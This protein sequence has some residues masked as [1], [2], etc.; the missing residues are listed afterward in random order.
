MVDPFG[1]GK[2]DLIDRTEHPM[3]ALL[4]SSIT[5]TSL[6]FLLLVLLALTAIAAPIVLKLEAHRQRLASEKNRVTA[7]EAESATCVADARKPVNNPLE[8]A[9]FELVGL[10]RGSSYA[11]RVL[12][13]QNKPISFKTVLEKIRGEQEL[14]KELNSLPASGI[15]AVLRILQGPGF[16]RMDPRGFVVTDLG[17]A[18]CQRIERVTLGLDC[19]RSAPCI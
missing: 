14:H 1:E 13:A 16:V 2:M 12:C 19:R 11:L 4:S 7:G 5:A 10:L 8:N 3:V 17:R 15:R 9:A 18:L 6:E